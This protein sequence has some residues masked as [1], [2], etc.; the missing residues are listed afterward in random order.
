MNQQEFHDVVVDNQPVGFL[1]KL[2]PPKKAPTGVNAD[3]AVPKV[4]EGL[5]LPKAAGPAPLPG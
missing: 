5:K 3:T 2:P 1:V 4:I